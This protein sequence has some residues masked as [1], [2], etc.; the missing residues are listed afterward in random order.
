MFWPTVGLSHTTQRHGNDTVECGPSSS[1]RKA[2]QYASSRFRT[3][4]DCTVILICHIFVVACSLSCFV[5]KLSTSSSS[6]PR[7]VCRDTCCFFLQKLLR[8]SVFSCRIQRS[9][10]KMRCASTRLH[11]VCCAHAFESQLHRQSCFRPYAETHD[12]KDMIYCST[13]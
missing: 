13:F 2:A 4:P 11:Q 10:R 7:Y 3:I 5:P 6:I 8:P 1:I 9:A 12:Q